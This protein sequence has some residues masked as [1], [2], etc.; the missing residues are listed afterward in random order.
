MNLDLSQ[1]TSD[2]AITAAIRQHITARLGDL[3]DEASLLDSSMVA[4]MLDVRLNDLPG[5]LPR[6]NV[7]AAGDKPRYRY[8][9]AD[10]R[11][12]ITER[13]SHPAKRTGKISIK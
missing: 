7:A 1:H 5:L 9:L 10:V 3:L 6:V 13:T 4:R 11:R 2:A 12:F 8:R